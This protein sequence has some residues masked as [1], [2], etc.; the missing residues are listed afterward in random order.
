MMQRL[1]RSLWIE[2][3]AKNGHIERL[4]YL[5]TIGCPWNQRAIWAVAKNGHL[6]CLILAPE[7]MSMG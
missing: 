4:K 7:W 3:A 6:E 2:E 1:L 5:H